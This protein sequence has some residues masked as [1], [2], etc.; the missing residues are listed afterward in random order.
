MSNLASFYLNTDLR[1]S[2]ELDGMSRP[3]DHVRVD[4]GSFLSKM[5]WTGD[6]SDIEVK[7]C[8]LSDRIDNRLWTTEPDI[9]AV[10]ASGHDL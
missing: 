8:N 5:A 6:R 10:L 4:E 2:S 9:A 3:G 1:V 7:C